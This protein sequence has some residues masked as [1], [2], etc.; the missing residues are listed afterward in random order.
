MKSPFSERN[1]Y[2]TNLQAKSTLQLLAE[3]REKQLREIESLKHE[4]NIIKG[5]NT[6]GDHLTGNDSK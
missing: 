5:K 6:Y 2:K 4:L 3:E 1:L